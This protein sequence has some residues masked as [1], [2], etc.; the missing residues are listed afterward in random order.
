VSS[1]RLIITRER[2]LFGMV[3]KDSVLI[4]GDEVAQLANGQ[5]LA[6]P[7]DS[8]RH[9]VRIGRSGARPNDLQINLDPGVQARLHCRRAGNPWTKIFLGRY[10]P[11][12][13]IVLSQQVTSA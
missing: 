5:E 11:R 2:D 12:P 9:V 3:R 7:V 8:G 13:P 10:W 4:D 6:I 1:A